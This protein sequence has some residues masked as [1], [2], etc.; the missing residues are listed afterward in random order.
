MLAPSF[1]GETSP[2]ASAVRR[3][4]VTS[5]GWRPTSVTIHPARIAPLDLGVAV[6]RENEASG[7]G[8]LDGEIGAAVL[9]VGNA[10]ERQGHAASGMPDRFEGRDFRGLVLERVE[11]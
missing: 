4:P 2:T 9:L 3:M 6:V 1:A 10:E 8:D 11:P 7:I 5:H